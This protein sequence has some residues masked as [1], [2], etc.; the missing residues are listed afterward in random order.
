[1]MPETDL[2][3]TSMTDNWMSLRLSDSGVV[4]DSP[5]TA[6]A[7]IAIKDVPH[8]LA[9]HAHTRFVVENA[10]RLFSHMLAA[11][12][13]S[14]NVAIWKVL[15]ENRVVGIALASQSL[16]LA[17]GG[18]EKNGPIAGCVVHNGR[19]LWE[20]MIKIARH[21]KVGDD[22]I[23][24]FGPLG[25]SLRVQG[26][27]ALGSIEHDGVRLA[28]GAQE[29]LIDQC[30]KR[31][32]ILGRD[33]SKADPSLGGSLGR[34]RGKLGKLLEPNNFISRWLSDQVK[35]LKDAQGAAIYPFLELVNEELNFDEPD[36]WPIYALGMPQVPTVAAM[37]AAAR[38]WRDLL[39]CEDGWLRPRY[40][41][42]SRI[43]MTT[44]NLEALPGKCEARPLFGPQLSN[45]PSS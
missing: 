4:V 2:V 30:Q 24:H 35:K 17:G 36:A 16:Q 9:S 34:I 3:G 23:S 18:H 37:I 29:V 7:T 20:D 27:A 26:A 41:I 11:E 25:Q 43:R 38:L 13:D 28:P 21:R 31:V 14:S 40:E 1:M 22:V 5:N 8:F 19:Q 45:Q 44:C 15:N 6:P 42:L 12:H 33:L 39:E 10:G 32:E